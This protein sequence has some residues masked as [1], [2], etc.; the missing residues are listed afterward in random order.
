MVLETLKYYPHLD[1]DLVLAGTILYDIGMI[2]SISGELISVNTE[3]GELIGESLL[4]RDIIIKSANDIAIIA[5]DLLL[6][7]Q[8]I[9][10]FKRSYLKSDLKNSSKLPEAIL[11]YYINK[12]N[13]KINIINDSL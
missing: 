6:K 8:Y 9:I 13:R 7:L 5:N 11:V 10:L 2:K 4:S 1:R 12:L 3:E